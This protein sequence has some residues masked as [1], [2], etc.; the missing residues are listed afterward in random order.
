MGYGLLRAGV[1]VL[2]E[3]EGILNVACFKE[4]A[5]ACTKL[6]HITCVNTNPNTKSAAIKLDTRASRAASTREINDGKK[7]EQRKA[8]KIPIGIRGRWVVYHL[9]ARHIQ[10]HHA[11]L[12]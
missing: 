9:E 3:F 2:V 10:Q 7:R 4:D 12:L 8:T 6:Q 5:I 1:K 11:W